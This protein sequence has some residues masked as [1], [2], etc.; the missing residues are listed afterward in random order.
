MAISATRSTVGSVPTA[1]RRG[2]TAVVAP[3]P[4]RLDTPD[5]LALLPQPAREGLVAV[6]VGVGAAVVIG[7][8]W[9]DT[10]P[11]SLHGAAALLTAAGRITGLLGAYLIL[12]EVLLMARLPWLD[13]AIGT[14][15]LAVWH[16]R[17]GEYAI[18]LLVAHAALT[19]WGYGLTDRA[20][21]ISETRT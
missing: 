1:T 6:V 18:T 15:R 7:L 9:R 10:S 8:W 11:H 12:V 20:N 13:T 3:A 19:I 5:P 4:S 17:N 14:D 16:R 2:P 21:P